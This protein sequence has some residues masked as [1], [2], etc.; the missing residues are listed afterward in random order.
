MIWEYRMR[1]LSTREAAKR[2]GI[3]RRNSREVKEQIRE[4]QK[5]LERQRPEHK[6]KS[7]ERVLVSHF[8]P[9]PGVRVRQRVFFCLR[10]VS[11]NFVRNMIQISYK[12]TLHPL[13][14]R[15]MIQ[16]SFKCGSLCAGLDFTS[17]RQFWIV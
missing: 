17:N 11:A 2:L 13:F 7:A 5:G 9:L 8:V 1:I 12:V 4:L 3:Q 10:E 6:S 15:S 16:T 14:V